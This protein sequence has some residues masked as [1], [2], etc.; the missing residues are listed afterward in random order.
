M[1]TQDNKVVEIYPDKEQVRRAFTDE[2]I[3]QRE[4]D[5]EADAL[6]KEAEIA[7]ANAKTA[8]LQRLGIT[9]EEAKLLL[10]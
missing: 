4:R 7:K 2:E 6:R 3:E 1:A 8:L 5:L 10:S 9:P